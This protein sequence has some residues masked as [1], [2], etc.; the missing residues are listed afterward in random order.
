MYENIYFCLFWGWRWKT[1]GG[2]RCL[3]RGSGRKEGEGGKCGRV[4]VIYN[5]QP[6][7]HFLI[8]FWKFIY[9]PR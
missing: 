9:C 2:C 3:G 8:F 5:R 4:V 6:I 1:R 7:Q